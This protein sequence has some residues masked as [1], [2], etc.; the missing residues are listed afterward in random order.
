MSTEPRALENRV[1]IQ[2]VID[3]AGKTD[4]T[5][6]L[7]AN[8]LFP[9]ERLRIGRMSEHVDLAIPDDSQMSK[10]HLEIQFDGVTCRLIDLGS[11]NGTRVNRELVGKAAILTD[12]DEIFA[13]QTFFRVGIIRVGIIGDEISDSPEDNA[14]AV[15]PVEMDDTAEFDVV[16]AEAAAA[17]AAGPSPLDSLPRIATLKLVSDEDLRASAENVTRLLAWVR[18]GQRITVGSSGFDSDWCIPEEWGVSPKHFQ[19]FFDGS[20]CVLQNYT[21]DQG[22]LLNGKPVEK[23]EVSNGD[24][25]RAGLANFIVELS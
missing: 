18:P 14:T 16:S 21:D 22:T 13:G 12:G 7:A 15:K 1:I 19:I 5:A 25:I 9:G 2:V 10:Q 6:T 4:G 11:A 24:T 20:V 23:T 3:A 17:E 8:W